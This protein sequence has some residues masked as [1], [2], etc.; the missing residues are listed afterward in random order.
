MSIPASFSSLDANHS[1][2]TVFFF[3]TVILHSFLCSA[4]KMVSAEESNRMNSFSFAV[5]DR[6]K[7]W[8]DFIPCAL[9]DKSF[10]FYCGLVGAF[11]GHCLLAQFPF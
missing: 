3:V 1:L 4:N 5:S 7:G 8:S 10:V 9:H 2:P 11:L 6:I